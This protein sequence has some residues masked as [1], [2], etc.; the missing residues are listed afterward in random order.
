M[1]L[2]PHGDSAVG[3][4]VP[5]SGGVA[6]FFRSS[7]CLPAGSSS[8]VISQVS[9]VLSGRL[10]LP[11]SL[12]LFR[13]CDSSAGLH[14]RHGPGLPHHT[15]VWLQDP[16]LPGLLA[17]HRIVVPGD[18]AGEGLSAIVVSG[19]GYSHQPGEELSDT[20]SVDRLPGDEASDVSFEGFPD[21]QTCPEAFI[22]RSRFLVLSNASLMVW[23]QLLGVMSSMSALMPGT[24]LRMRSL[25]LRL[26]VEGPSLVDSDKVSWDDSCLEDLRW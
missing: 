23:R 17:R 10:G 22:S 12:F 6:Y 13:P 7:G 18:C 3:A 4:P 15:S 19:A 26:N 21:P 5:P 25:Q 11:V 24:C 14:P 9:E 20:D 2:F 8:S 16:S 1:C